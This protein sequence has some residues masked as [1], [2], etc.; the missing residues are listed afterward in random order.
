MN[1]LSPTRWSN[2]ENAARIA[3]DYPVGQSRHDGLKAAYGEITTADLT[4]TDQSACIVLT[5][6]DHD[7]NGAVTLAETSMIMRCAAND[8]I[9]KVDALVDDDSEPDDDA[10][11]S[12]VLD[13]KLSNGDVVD[14]GKRVLPAQIAMSLAPD[15]V[16]RWLAERP[17]PDTV[18]NRRP[19][20]LS[21]DRFPPTNTTAGKP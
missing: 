11:F 4:A 17:E 21:L 18:V 6:L 19:S 15:A 5:A 7:Q 3:N 2:L 12:F 1:K 14:T 10:A 20:S 16:S 8:L 9:A 13:L